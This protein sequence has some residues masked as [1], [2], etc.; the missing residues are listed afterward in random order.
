MLSVCS[1]Q[2]SRSKHGTDTLLLQGCWQN[3]GTAFS[4]HTDSPAP[5]RLSYQVSLELGTPRC[6]GLRPPGSRNITKTTMRTER[7]HRSVSLLSPPGTS[8]GLLCPPASEQL[9]FNAA[10]CHEWTPATFQ[11][12]RCPLWVAMQ[13]SPS[14]VTLFTPC[15]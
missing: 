14:I 15:G 3:R 7:A 11:T 2:F 1:S 5:Q 13:V 6:R 9:H 12:F 10:A 4:Y 8:L